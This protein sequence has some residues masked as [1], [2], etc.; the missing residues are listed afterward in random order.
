MTRFVA[1]YRVSTVRQGVSGL[2]LDAQRKS[3]VDFVESRGGELVEEWTEVESGSQDA[4]PALAAALA[5][6]R[7]L[8]ATLV[9]AKLDRLSRS[10]RLIAEIMDAGVSFVCADM[11]E[12]SEL[13]IHIIAALAQYERKLISQRTKEALAALK[14]RG[15]K[16]GNPNPKASGVAR[17]R[18][19]RSKAL[20][21]SGQ[22]RFL[23]SQGLTVKQM[24]D[25]LNALQVPTP[26]NNPYWYTSLVQRVWTKIQASVH[27]EEAF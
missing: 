24:A 26:N 22:F 10:V 19:S 11:P 18:R 23:K 16:L 3:V 15:V 5:A 27:V 8:E 25:T 7:R 20:Q 4:R 6:A 17:A 12:A 13:T 9:V 21:Y 14:A 1:Y 2:G